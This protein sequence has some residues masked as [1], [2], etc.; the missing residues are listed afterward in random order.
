MALT[1]ILVP[2][3]LR[4]GWALGV[5]ERLQVI[6]VAHTAL[7]LGAL[8]LAAT[9]AM[10]TALGFLGLGVPPPRV[11]LG[12]ML[13]EGRQYLSV[14]SWIAIIPGIVLSL[15]TATWLV[16]AALFSRS[17]PVYRAVRWIHIMS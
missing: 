5:G 4:V 17:G 10:S 1:V 11:D 14:A 15:I 7:R 3:A 9:L 16:V 12:A 2:R 13:A 8:F 6:H